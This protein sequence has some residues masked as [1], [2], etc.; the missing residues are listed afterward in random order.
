MKLFYYSIILILFIVFSMQITSCAPAPH[1]RVG[2][3]VNVPNAWN[4]PYPAPADSS[5]FGRPEPAP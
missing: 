4:G 5:E 1:V 2:V 3:D